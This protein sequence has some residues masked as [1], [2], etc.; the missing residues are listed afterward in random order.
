VI[1]ERLIDLIQEG[2]R[3]RRERRR[4]GAT[5]G[6]KSVEEKRKDDETID[7]YDSDLDDEYEDGFENLFDSEDL[8]VEYHFDEE[9]DDD[10]A[11]V[12]GESVEYWS[13]KLSSSGSSSDE[14]NSAVE[15]W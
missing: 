6:D 12:N 2:K 4:K 13:R 7:D 1:R 10:E 8:G 3:I 15:S 9:D 11:G 5:L 14:A